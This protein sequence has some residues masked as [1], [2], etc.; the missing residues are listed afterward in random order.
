MSTMP[1]GFRVVGHRA[2]RRRIVDWQSAFLAHAACDERAELGREGYLSHFTF[3]DTFRDHF[4]LQNSEAGYNGP[5]AAHWLFWDID[6]PDDLEAAISD[7]RRL[8]AN[9][10]DRYR[11][12]D[13]D[14]LLVLLSGAKGFHVGIPTALW[15]PTPSLSFHETAKRFA[16]AHAARAGIVVDGLIYSKT[17]LF[18]APNSKHQKTGLFKRRLALGELNHLSTKGIVELARHPEP[19]ALSVPTVT[20]PTAIADWLDAGR[21]VEK[22]AVERRAE[23]GNGSPRLNLKTLD[24]IRDGSTDGERAIRLFQAAANLGEFD[25]PPALAHALLNE[26]ALDSGLTPRETMR[27]IESGLTHARRQREGGAS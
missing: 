1:Y 22:R 7:S 24:F 18:R 4:D 26:S 25:C 16:L 15:K 11:E 14:A 12:L 9:I 20:S 21:A 19:F 23:Y 17:R 27:Q 8:A 10:L 13:D 3:D 6:R 2:G 5:C